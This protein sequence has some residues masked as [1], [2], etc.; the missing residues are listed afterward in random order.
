MVRAML[1]DVLGLKVHVETQSRPV[2]DLVVAAGGP[3]LTESM[4]D[5]D[6]PPIPGDVIWINRREAVYTKT[7]MRGLA[8]GLSAR[9]DRDVVDKTGLTG[10]YDFHVKPLPFPHYDRSSSTA[11]TKELK[12][13]VDGVKSLGLRLN[14][15]N[16]DTA[17]MHRSTGR[18]NP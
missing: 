17:I 5:P 16:A 2:Y 18:V 1:A 7:T 10:T 14:P 12:A 3:N 6:T 15:D 4:S 8:T 11:K 13:I 9:L